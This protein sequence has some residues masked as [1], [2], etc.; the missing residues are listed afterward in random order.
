MANVQIGNSTAIDNIQ[1]TESSSPSNPASG[2]GRL[3]LSDGKLYFVNDTPHEIEIAPAPLTET[4]WAGA[5]ETGVYFLG[6]DSSDATNY[7]FN[8]DEI[9]FILKYVVSSSFSQNCANRTYEFDSATDRVVTI[10][11]S[12]IVEGHIIHAYAK[13]VSGGTGHSILL[14]TG[15]SWNNAGDR[16]VIFDAVDD[17]LYARAVSST[18]FVVFGNVGLSFAAS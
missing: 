11:T 10:N 3:Y 5:P 9:N 18:R 6:Q 17:A 15:C 14:P 8:G 4:P 13:Q 12:T 16:R 1:F 2:F 7:Y